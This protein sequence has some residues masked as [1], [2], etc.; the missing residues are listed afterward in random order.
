MNSQEFFNDADTL[1][2]VPAI[3][4]T[5]RV[6]VPEVQ[7]HTDKIRISPMRWRALHASMRAVALPEATQQ[8]LNIAMQHVFMATT[9]YFHE[10]LETAM[11]SQVASALQRIH[12]A[13]QGLF[14]DR[15]VLFVDLRLVALCPA[16]NDASVTSAVQAAEQAL[17][18]RIIQ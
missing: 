11:G 14:V 6:L 18:S 3:K 7:L 2:S 1:V 10:H 8:P 15:N 17:L 9:A 16:G 5:T 13:G 4:R 12:D